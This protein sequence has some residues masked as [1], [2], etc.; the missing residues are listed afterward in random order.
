MAEF[1]HRRLEVWQDARALVKR[2]YSVSAMFPKTERFGLMD[3]INRAAVSVPSNIAEG[4][5]RETQAD[6]V[7][8]LVIARGSLSEIDTQ[9]TLAEDLGYIEQQDDL[10]NEVEVLA[11][12]LNRLI[13]HVRA[14]QHPTL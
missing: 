8:F 6:F 7:H 4:S 5:S 14:A 11:C 3:Q 12:R 10:H 13:A 1:K 2:V 9:L